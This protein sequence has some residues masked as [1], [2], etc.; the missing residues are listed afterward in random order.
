MGNVFDRL[1][2]C[3]LA[4]CYPNQGGENSHGEQVDQELRLQSVEEDSSLEQ[5]ARVSWRNFRG[6]THTYKVANQTPYIVKI[7]ATDDPEG[8]VRM[9]A[10]SLALPSRFNDGFSAV[11][12][13]RRGGDRAPDH[14][15][16][17]PNWDSEIRASSNPIF[18]AAGLY[19]ER[20]VKV[21]WQ[22]RRVDAGCNVN[23]QRKHAEDL[24][25]EWLQVQTLEKALKNRASGRV[26]GSS[27]TCT[28]WLWQCGCLMIR[29]PAPPG[30]AVLEATAICGLQNS[31]PWR[32]VSA[33]LY[34]LFWR[35]VFGDVLSKIFAQLP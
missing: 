30:Q 16:I 24:S 4:S 15:T 12:H 11:V 35:K 22:S 5:T 28:G 25:E 9:Y 2:S 21:I 3:I 31:L 7:L 10:G 6:S 19:H 18:I 20:Q 26:R 13:S 33:V 14:Y 32:C 17:Q 34:G 23:I 29:F 27:D 1:S 8:L